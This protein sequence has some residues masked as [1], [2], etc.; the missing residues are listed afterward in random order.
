[1]Q[2]INGEDWNQKDQ[3][4]PGDFP[5]EPNGTYQNSY[6]TFVENCGYTF[7]Q[8]KEMIEKKLRKEFQ[9]TKTLAK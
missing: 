6:K 7:E 4:L 9:K 2:F 5:E 3:F 1:V 8:C